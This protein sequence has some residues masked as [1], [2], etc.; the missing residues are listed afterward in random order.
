MT[1]EKEPRYRLE[2]PVEE[3]VLFEKL[4]PA[5][6]A[7]TL[8]RP[9]KLNA[10]VPPDMFRELTRKIEMA[11]DDPGVK[12]IILRG[13]GRSFCTGDDLNVA[14]YDS[15]G[16]QPGVR[17]SQRV[18][19]Q[20]VL[21]WI[22]DLYRALLYCPKT[23]ICQ[24]KGWTIGL[25]LGILFCCDMA[26][27]PESAQFSQRHQR[28]G[29]AGFSPAWQLIQLLTIGYKRMRDWQ[30]TGRTLDARTALDWGIVN[31]VVP[32]DQLEAETLRWARA[33]ALNP[34]DGLMIA[35]AHLHLMLDLLGMPGQY[36]AAALAHPLFTNLKW[37]GEEFNFL[38]RRNEVGASRAF[39]E[40]EARW[41]E[42]GF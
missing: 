37:E 18:R 29:F 38:R 35:K 20:A 23:I 8:N 15:Y 40:R 33:V 31:E 25:G 14:P 41:G 12:V 2:K 32:D 16:G 13:A 28:T 6:A 27:A 22:N 4:E 5:I 34:A 17:P 3:T 26:I 24:P 36:S 11:V 42:L 9:E 1:Q 30:L 39:A 7:V 21:T 19:V 10:F